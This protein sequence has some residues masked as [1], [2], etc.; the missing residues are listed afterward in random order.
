MFLPVSVFK[1]IDRPFL[2]RFA[3]LWL[4]YPS[5]GRSLVNSFS[6][7]PLR[8]EITSCGLVIGAL[9]YD[10]IFII[11]APRSPIR[12]LPIGPAQTSVN[13]NIRIFFKG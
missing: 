11:S 3:I 9:G 2:L 8:A 10:S 12:E 7:N 5:Q 13:S 1:S 6:T 4:A